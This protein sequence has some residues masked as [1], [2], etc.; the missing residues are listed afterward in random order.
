MKKYLPERFD[1]SPPFDRTRV[2]LLHR[3]PSSVN[4]EGVPV[5]REALWT[6][7]IDATVIV[8]YGPVVLRKAVS[9]AMR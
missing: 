5:G 4:T 1:L 7:V 2:E 6:A 8:V 3:A 9:P